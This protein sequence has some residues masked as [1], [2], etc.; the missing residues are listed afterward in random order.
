MEKRITLSTTLLL[1]I[2]TG[3]KVIK[4]TAAS[5][6]ATAGYTK[7]AAASVNAKSI[8]LHTVETMAHS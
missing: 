5:N 4:D 8:Q 6:Q 2:K 3:N 1:A 7:V